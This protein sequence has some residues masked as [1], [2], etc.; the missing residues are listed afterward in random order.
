MILK[1]YLTHDSALSGG[2]AP[3]LVIRWEDPEMTSPDEVGV[4]DVEE[5]TG[6]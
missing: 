4:V 6:T 3:W 5:G 1:T 2:V